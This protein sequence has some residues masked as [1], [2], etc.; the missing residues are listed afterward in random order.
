MVW[1]AIW[2]DGNTLAGYVMFAISVA[3]AVL[4]VQ[5][6]VYYFR[7]SRMEMYLNPTI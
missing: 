4:F 1:V 3:I 7:R 6:V 5:R 2:P